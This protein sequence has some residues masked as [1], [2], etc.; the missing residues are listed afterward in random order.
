MDNHTVSKKVKLK[1]LASLLQIEFYLGGNSSR[2]SQFLAREEAG[3]IEIDPEINVVFI[4]ATGGLSYLF[5]GASCTYLEIGEWIGTPID[6][7]SAEWNI[8]SDAVAV[9]LIIDSLLT[10]EQKQYTMKFHAVVDTLFFLQTKNSSSI[11]AN[12]QTLSNWLSV[13]REKLRFFTEPLKE[14]PCQIENLSVERDMQRIQQKYEF[15]QKRVDYDRGIEEAFRTWNRRHNEMEGDVQKEIEKWFKKV[16]YELPPDKPSSLFT[17]YSHSFGYTT[18]S[19]REWIYG[20]DFQE[21]SLE[22]LKEKF[23]E[24]VDE[25][26]IQWENFIDEINKKYADQIRQFIDKIIDMLASSWEFEVDFPP[27]TEAESPSYRF[28]GK[29]I[30]PNLEFSKLLALRSSL[31]DG[32]YSALFAAYIGTTT[33]AGGEAATAGDIFIGV[34]VG[35]AI[36]ALLAANGYHQKMRHAYAAGHAA[37]E[38]ELNHF[39]YEVSCQIVQDLNKRLRESGER[40]LTALKEA[41]EETEKKVKLM[42]YYPE[43]ANDVPDNKLGEY[44][45][46]LE[47]LITKRRE[48]GE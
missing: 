41:K 20:L 48:V 44:D 46:L 26:V 18:P 3:K 15:L 2:R 9:V 32:L 22:T 45:G 4:G 17:A 36:A 43:F 30:V 8:I 35:V 28:K 10:D 34:G 37:V 40:A 33:A 14:I 39:L 13:D 21:D 29:V 6:T 25:L 16:G 23:E 42:K 11:N 12:K 31:M 19:V 38:K 1:R 27:K 7:P 24:F 47:T 5:A